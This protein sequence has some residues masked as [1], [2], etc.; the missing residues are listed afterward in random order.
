[1]YGPMGV[2]PSPRTTL[3]VKSAGSNMYVSPTKEG[4]LIY[5]SYATP[6]AAL[7][8]ETLQLTDQTYSTSTKG[9]L[10][11]LQFKILAG[12]YTSTEVVSSTD[13]FVMSQ[14]YESQPH[15]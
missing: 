5:F 9:H 12:K 4:H 3:P 10:R 6:V 13:L 8:G 11:K 2:C 14:G 7:V 15:A 1:M